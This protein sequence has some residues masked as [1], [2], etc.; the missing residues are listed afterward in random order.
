[1]QSGKVSALFSLVIAGLAGGCGDKGGPASS[2]ETPATVEPAPAAAAAPAP[3]EPNAA[4]AELEAA[5]ACVDTVVDVQ[6]AANKAIELAKC[7]DAAINDPEL[8]AWW[9]SLAGAPSPEAKAE[10]LRA[11]MERVGLEQCKLENVWTGQPP[12]AP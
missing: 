3:A 2:T 12:E 1:M 11:Q 6:D 10:S 9:E 4:R 8:Q 5:C 7:A